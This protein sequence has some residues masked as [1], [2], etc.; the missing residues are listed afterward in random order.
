MFHK[1]FEEIFKSPYNKGMKRIAKSIWAEKGG[2][3]TFRIYVHIL[4]LPTSSFS[5]SIVGEGISE[6]SRGT[7]LNEHVESPEW[8]EDRFFIL[9]IPSLKVTLQDTKNKERT[10]FEQNKSLWRKES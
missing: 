10:Y 4:P 8:K 2:S 6:K 1:R 5:L 3:D 7:L 9:Y